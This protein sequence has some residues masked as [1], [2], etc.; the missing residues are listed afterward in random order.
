MYSLNE[1]LDGWITQHVS[2]LE[3][4]IIGLKMRGYYLK[5]R[6]EQV[7]KNLVL[8][9]NPLG[10]GLPLPV[11]FVPTTPLAVWGRWPERYSE[12]GSHSTVCGK[13]SAW[14]FPLSEVASVLKKQLFVTL[15]KDGDA[16]FIRGPF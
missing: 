9:K 8:I 4:R 14:G 15:V 2:T 6:R 1:K 5:Y 16:D 13:Q 12:S 3:E 7:P 10:V 11:T